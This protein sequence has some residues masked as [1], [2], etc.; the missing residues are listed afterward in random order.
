M[1]PHAVDYRSLAISRRTFLQA[2]GLAFACRLHPICARF[3]AI[4][5]DLARLF[6]WCAFG[7]API[8]QGA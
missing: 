5:D 8:W 1:R 6:R 7:S 3:T 2:M 4:A